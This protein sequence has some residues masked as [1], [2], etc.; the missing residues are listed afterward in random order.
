MV[1]TLKT[2]EQS[3]DYLQRQVLTGKDQILGSDWPEES[4]DRL[5]EANFRN[6]QEGKLAVT[7]R[8]Q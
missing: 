6:N 2:K 7:W 5:I 8:K 4:P 1:R 3:L